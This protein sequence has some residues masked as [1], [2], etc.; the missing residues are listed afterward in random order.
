MAATSAAAAAQRCLSLR[1]VRLSWPS[2]VAAPC[3]IPA[4][5]H[6]GHVTEPGLR[7][8][9]QLVRLERLDLLGLRALGPRPAV[10]STRWFS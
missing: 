6:D 4:A 9:A 8:P 10:N 2:G 7:Q 1:M 5:R 3:R